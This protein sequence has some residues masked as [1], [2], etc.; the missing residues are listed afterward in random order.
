M[1]IRKFTE[2]DHQDL[3]ETISDPAVMEYIEPPYTEEKTRTFL[4]SAALGDAPK[5][6]AAENNAGEYV[7]YVIYH[8]Y[9]PGSVEIGWLLKKSAWGR[10]YARELT[11]MMIDKAFRDG[12]DVV[13][14]C[15]PGQAVT[16]H[17]A[18]SFGF[19]NEGMTDGCCVYRLKRQE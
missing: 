5:I 19:A 18:E 6:Y 15:D 10:G 4:R 17:I 3:Y 13:I 7:G 14:E 12:K 16:K 11:K 9:D 2:A 1:K 8:E